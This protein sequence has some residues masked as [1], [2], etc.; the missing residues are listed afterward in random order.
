MYVLPNIGHIVFEIVQF[1]KPIFADY[2]L[3]ALCSLIV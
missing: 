2:F 1:G 3:D